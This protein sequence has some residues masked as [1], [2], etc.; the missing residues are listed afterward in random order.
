MFSVLRLGP[1]QKE[2]LGY[3]DLDKKGLEC[4]VYVILKVEQHTDLKER[5]VF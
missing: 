3:N 4:Y 2:F 1:I 5:S